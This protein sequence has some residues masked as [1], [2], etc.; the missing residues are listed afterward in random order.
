MLKEFDEQAQKA[1]VVAE[2][3]SFDF[4]HQNVGSEHLL[5]SLLKMHDNQLKRFLKK[6]KVNE[7]VVEG[8]IKRLFGTSED[9]SQIPA[10]PCSTTISGMVFSLLCGLCIH[11]VD[12]RSNVHGCGAVDQAAPASHA[13]WFSVSFFEEAQLVHEALSY[14]ISLLLTGVVIARHECV[15]LEHA[16]IPAAEAGI[17]FLFSCLTE[18]EAVAS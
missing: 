3:I 15:I 14:T 12:N 16:A 10:H 4:G 18:I 9:P 7:E 11:T 13:E 2:S 5:L 17:F 8:D 6:Y 1:I